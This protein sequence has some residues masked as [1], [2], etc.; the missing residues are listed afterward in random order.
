M[1]PFRQIDRKSAYLLPPSMNEWL[2]EDHL[3]R[4]ILEAIEK[5]DLSALIR[6]YARRGSAA[7]HRLVYGYA[8]GVFSRRRL[9]R[10]THESVA[11]RFLAAGSHPNHDTL[12]NKRSTTYPNKSRPDL[13]SGRTI[14]EQN[15]E[16]Q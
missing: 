7:Y 10:A 5:L 2:P 11:F 3:V 6:A 4:F 9:E 14:R 8:T 12:A 1:S 15:D 16:S 13:Q